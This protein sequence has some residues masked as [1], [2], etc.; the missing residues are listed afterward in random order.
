MVVPRVPPT[1]IIRD[2]ISMK[3]VNPPPRRIARMT[4]PNAEIIPISVAISIDPIPQLL[5]I[6]SYSAK[7]D[8]PDELGCSIT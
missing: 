3:S 5:S 7:K 6:N 1:T 2:F 8:A 4:S